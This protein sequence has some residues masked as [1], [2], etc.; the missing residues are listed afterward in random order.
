MLTPALVGVLT[1]IPVLGA[2]SD[3]TPTANPNP[4]TTSQ[5]VRL[6]AD[7][8]D[9][10]LYVLD[11]GG[12]HGFPAGFGDTTPLGQF[13][14]SSKIKDPLYENPKTGAVFPGA[15]GPWFF[16]FK[17]SPEGYYGIHAGDI[18]APSDGCIRLREADVMAIA[19]LISPGTPIE[20]RP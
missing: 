1:M 15:L 17:N 10:A 6:I 5:G 7:I 3:P 19:P 8:S 11:G 20:I 14:I 18:D 4:R 9:R 13:A 2:I 16:G 12:Q